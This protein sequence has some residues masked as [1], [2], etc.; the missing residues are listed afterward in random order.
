MSTGIGRSTDPPMV[1]VHQSDYLAMLHYDEMK[2]A[3]QEGPV[4]S[5]TRR[6]DV[7]L[8]PLSAEPQRRFLPTASPA[9]EAQGRAPG[10]T[11]RLAKLELQ[12]G[13]TIGQTTEETDWLHLLIEPSALSSE[14]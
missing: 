2:A 13:N 4:L 8:P 14:K 10:R 6:G 5:N 11:P 7:Y 1:T 3:F 9:V 12:H